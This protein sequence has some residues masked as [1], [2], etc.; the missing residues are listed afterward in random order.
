MLA[1]HWVRAYRRLFEG[2]EPWEGAV[3][4]TALPVSLGDEGGGAS[5]EPLASGVFDEAGGL[6]EHGAL[7]LLLPP[8]ALSRPVEIGIYSLGSTH[9]V[10]E[11]RQNVTDGAQ[12]YRFLPAGLEF[13][14]PVEISL[15]YDKNRESLH[16]HLIIDE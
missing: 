4:G 16:G 14:V 12:A 11:G 8:G 3:A 13:A 7:R 2:R 5:L 10:P 6:L 9:E 15:P 1:S